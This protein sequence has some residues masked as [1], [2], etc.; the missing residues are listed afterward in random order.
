ME[1]FRSIETYDFWELIYSFEIKKRSIM[2]DSTANLVFHAPTSLVELFKKE[3]PG[4]DIN[5]VVESKSRLKDKLSFNRDK[6]RIDAQLFKTLFDESLDK[7]VHHMQHI[8]RNPSVKDVP[9]ILLVGGFAESP[10]LQMTIEKAFPNK[11]V[12]IPKGAGLAVMKGAV[13]Y[14]HEPK[15]VSS[16]V[17]RKTYGVRVSAIFDSA[18]HPKSKKVVENGVDRCTDIF[19]IHVHVGESVEVGEPQ[20]EKLY[21]VI[22]PNQKEIT[23]SIYASQNKDPMFTTDKGCKCLGKLKINM[24]DITKGLDRGAKVQMTFSGTEIHVK[25]TDKDN[26]EN[27]VKTSVDFLG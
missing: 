26:S 20:V 9:S 19:N 14:G 11:K 15:T 6:L 22:H 27:I 1:A 17:C 16:R 5:A 12:I 7:I 25:A 3:N 21:S 23:F 2:P 8:F 18:I 4:K 10:M 13:L 24:P